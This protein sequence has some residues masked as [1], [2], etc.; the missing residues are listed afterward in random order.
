M[1]TYA[2]T[3]SGGK[4]SCFAHWKAIKNGL[5]V[6]YLLNFIN[7]DS[8]KSASHGLDYRL[9]A[10]QAQA[11]KL[12]IIQQKVTQGNYE[13]GFKAAL[14]DLKEKGFTGLITGDIYLQEHRDWIERVC[15]EAGMEAVL[16]LWQM[17]TSQLLTNFV[18]ANFKS[19]IVSVKNDFSG[20]NWLGKELDT[21]L[22]SELKQLAE[23]QNIDPA[24]EHGE[25]HTFVY[26]GPTFKKSIKIIKSTVTSKDNHCF[27]DILD[28]DL[29]N[30]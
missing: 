22:A 10:L 16:P 3:W 14:H 18:A 17:N 19:V 29:Y 12:P 4:D 28:Y 30:K 20:N 25:Y 9:I 5:N 15:R 21:E 1:S 13:A 26:D 2:A 6:S 11:M 8:L 23:T 24:G 27:L 7:K